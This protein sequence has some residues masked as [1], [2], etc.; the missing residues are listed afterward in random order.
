MTPT[1]LNQ[2]RIFRLYIFQSH[3]PKT[4]G[5]LTL[6]T[7]WFWIFLPPCSTLISWKALL[8]A[9]GMLK[10]SPALFHIYCFLI[11]VVFDSSIPSWVLS[12]ES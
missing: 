8:L 6:E 4:L 7:S 5:T 10:S 3:L 1:L 2:M 11:W 9:L 12:S